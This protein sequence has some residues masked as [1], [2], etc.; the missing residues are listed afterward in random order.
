MALPPMN[1]PSPAS[2]SLAS[3]VPRSVEM[4]KPRCPSG[5]SVNGCDTMLVTACGTKL[6]VAKVQ[7]DAV[8]TFD[9][10]LRSNQPFFSGLSGAGA[11]CRT[12]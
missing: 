12:R 5:F 11:C 7:R 1:Q 9:A 8:R 4:K 3:I 2:L 10:M 6:S